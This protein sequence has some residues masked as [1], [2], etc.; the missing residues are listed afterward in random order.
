MIICPNNCKNYVKRKLI[1][2]HFENECEKSLINCDFVS[3]GC[4]VKVFLCKYHKL[5]RNLN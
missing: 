2:C 5:K 4:D 3:Y 1:H